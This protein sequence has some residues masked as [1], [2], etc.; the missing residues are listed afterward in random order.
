MQRRDFLKLS[1][2]AG[3]VSC[4]TA[5]GSKSSDSPAPVAPAE[6]QLNWTA[7]LVNCGSNCPLKVYSVDGVCTRVETDWAE[8]D[9]YGNHQVRACLRG[10]SLRQRNYAPDRLKT[11]LRRVAGTKR[12]AGQWEQISWETAFSEIGTKL[13][14]LKADHGPR[15]IYHHYVSGAYYSF[16]SGNCIRRALDCAGGERGFLAYYSNYSWAALTETAGATFGHGATSGTRHSHIRDADFFL[17]IGFNPFEMR[18]SGSGEQIDFMK[19]VEERRANGQKFKAIMI[20]PRYTDSNLGKE[21]EWLPIRPGTDGAM[22]AAIAYEMMKGSDEDHSDSWVELNSRDFLNSYTVGYDAA[23][24]RAAIAADPTLQ[25]KHD[26]GTIAITVDEMAANNYKDYILGSGKF[27]AITGTAPDYEKGAKDAEWA[28]AIC[29]IPADKLR[30]IASEL[31]ASSNPYIQIGAGPNR[32]A[33]GE[34]TMRS[35]YMLS[36]LAG[37]L[38]QAG[39]NTGELPSNFRHNT[40]GMGYSYADKDGSKA[41][42]CFF[43]WVEAV[44]D[45]KDMDYR[46]HG[47]KIYNKDGELQRDEKLGTDIKAVFC[48][49]GNG[50]INQHCDI[51]YTRPILEDESKA[52]LIVVTDCWLTPSAEIAD[53]VLPDST[54]MESNDIADDSYSSGETGY[55]TYMSSSLKPFFES[56]KSMYDIGLGIVKASGGDVSTYTDGK[57]DASEWLDELYE[58]TKAKSQNATLNLPATYAEAQAKGFFRGHAPDRGPLTLESFVNEGA[59]LSTTTGKI[60]IFSFKWA[61]DNPRRDTFVADDRDASTHV[62]MIDPTPKYVPHWQGFEDD[63]TPQGKEEVENYPLQVCGYHTK[64]RA[65]SS[66]HNVKWLRDA[67]EDCVWVNPADAGEFNSGDEVIMESPRGKLQI[68]MRITPRVAP[69]VVALPEGAWYKASAAGEVDSGGCVNTLT[70]YHPCPVSRGNTQ[71]T[72]RV[73]LYKANA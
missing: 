7:C 58:Q 11:P 17:G 13:A 4:I 57:A 64:G 73:K 71:H 47:V 3:A 56:T 23:S 6:E 54:W 50:L 26:D 21:D 29:G 12:G 44:K 42:L 65:H 8:S 9:D 62:D 51:N 67:V 14:Q 35:L 43:D 61:I 27:D 24:I 52:E 18:M 53:Y 70:K 68:R 59:A 25:P 49:A 28:E 66:Y 16:A 41:S 2:T 10:R 45:G 40:A 55:Q 22:A 69:G 20:D 30:E 31:M 34:Q 37:K 1:A 33:A 19:A 72:I 15:S 60:E 36:I 32:Q 63:D 46:S 5:C 48:S 38:G 39:T